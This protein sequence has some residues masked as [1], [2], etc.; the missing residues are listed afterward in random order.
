MVSGATIAIAMA[1]IL[2]GIW[3]APV[4]LLALASPL[5]GLG[6]N[7]AIGL[8]LLGLGLY[9]PRTRLWL[10][11]FVAVVSVVVIVQYLL[12]WLPPDGPWRIVLNVAG[13]LSWPGRMAPLTAFSLLCG[14][15]GLAMLER[16]RSLWLQ[17]LLQILPGLIV[18]AV[19]GGSL[20][21]GLN[22]LLLAATLESHATMSVPTVAA[23]LVFVLGYVAAMAEMPWLRGFY[24]QREERQILAIGLGGFSTALLLGGA[25]VIGMLGHQMQGLLEGSISDAANANAATLRQSISGA[26]LDMQTHGIEG[27]THGNLPGLLRNLAGADGAAWLEGKAASHEQHA[28]PEPRKA[29][30]LVRLKGGADNWLAWNGVWWLEARFPAP[31]QQ[32]II[33]VQARLH[34]LDKLFSGN[35]ARGTETFL[36]GQSDDGRTRC[37][38]D[39]LSPEVLLSPTRFDGRSGHGEEDIAKQQGVRIALDYRGA[40][41]VVAHLQLQE[42]GLELERKVDA[43]M[44]YHPLRV[45][46]WRA[47]LLVLGIGVVAVALIQTRVR[48][49]TRRAIETSRQLSGVLEVLPVG[50]WVTDASGRFILNNAAGKRIWARE[51]WT[52]AP[53]CCECKG[54][55]HG[56]GECIEPDD[57]A[58]ARAIERGETSLDE[59]IDIESFD[60]SRK[61]ISSS[62]LP[63]R[64]EKGTVTGV[65]AVDQDITERMLAEDNLKA[66]RNLLATILENV[67]IRVF[68]KDRACRYLGCNTAFARDAGMSCPE[69]VI[70]KDDFQMSWRAQAELYRADDQAVMDSDTP[71]IG[72][73]EQQLTPDGCMLWLRTS[74]VPLHDANGKV[75]GVLGIY[76]DITAYRGMMEE[77]RREKAKLDEA[78][79]VGGMGS[80]ELD[81]VENVLTWSDEMYRI[82]EIDPERFGASY[83]AFL[84]TLHPDD[85]ER[86][87]QIYTRSLETREPYEVEHRLLFPDGRI[88]HVI[89]R[90]ETFRDAADRLLRSVG[91]TQDI[92]GRVDAE[93]EIRRLEREFH[94]LAE[95]MPDVIA[96]FDRELRRIYVNPEFERTTGISREAALGK[97]HLEL[98]INA[99]V[100]EAW[101]NALRRVLFTEEPE[102]FEFHFPTHS[103]VIR[104]F[105]VRAVPEYG[106]A[107]EVE[108]V[109]TIAR[110][111]SA[112]K[113]VEAVLRENEARFHAITRNVPG[114]VFQ[115][116]RRHGEETLKFTYVSEGAQGLLGLNPAEIQ[117]DAIALTG[118]M[119]ED[120]MRA[121]RDSL[122][123]SQQRLAMWNW[124][125]R[126]AAKDGSV[127]WISVRA[128][129]RCHAD[130]TCIW[131]GVAINVSD[132]KA[133]EEQLV[134]SQKILRDL[135]SHLEIVRE[136]ERK[137][138]AREIHDELGQTLTAL[139][140]DVSLA[141]LGFGES[142]PGLMERLQ[143]MT[144]LV[145]RTI[146]VARHVTSSLRPAALDLGVTA[147][148]EW[149]VEEFVSY[150]GIHCELVLGDGELTLNEASATTIFRVIQESLTNIAR[151]AE[152]TQAEIIVTMDDNRLCFEVRDNGKGFDPQ[153]AAGRQ[154]FGLV[155]MRERV[156][157]LQGEMQL[158][159]AP[160]QGTRV[161]VC[162]PV[163]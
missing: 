147:A 85:R 163:A 106:P 122:V 21:R 81:L 1:A 75:I 123:Q 142:N 42:L 30:L 146:K 55:W 7:T 97:T 102:V 121:F 25:A 111:I 83:E 70:G 64:D 126:I 80:W 94:S 92:T 45:T 43:E 156:S 9:F 54:S 137:H 31:Q 2:L 13:D 151:H 74:K 78:Q 136:Q 145:D 65:V 48:R 96:R 39:G 73:E 91:T 150:A 128:I 44:L 100:A 76:D 29:R 124:E 71:K 133:H 139:R 130:G 158:D 34:E 28:G 131:D 58:I 35:D 26:L 118:R 37:F 132:S 22:G 134:Q 56:T 50:V 125:G 89:E 40:L 149:L 104:H 32:G 153:A 129:P 105:Q 101:T 154:S 161:K 152:A 38:P 84:D 52:G 16:P 14:G 33:V 98:G 23:M 67:P 112:M 46:L 66:S 135:S 77:L 15:V 6:L 61:I 90:C 47:I 18:V 41:V 108:T 63:L 140:M 107:G 141:R 99:E 143:S 160:G 95:N 86:V 12:S 79:R 82:F 68:W 59:V 116:Y 53:K 162:V 159:S 127:R 93:T 155:G 17:V 20:N 72:Y 138:I 69:N 103:G 10:G 113:G 3:L 88:K 8:L 119:P 110:D 114:M 144:Q 24:A 49:V 117:A 62:T 5:S 51:D 87:N 60:G 115:C 157:M 36:C 27:A 57:W 109:L 4:F 11:G 148:L 19:V 120:D